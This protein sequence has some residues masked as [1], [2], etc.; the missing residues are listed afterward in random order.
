MPRKSQNGQ[1]DGALFFHAVYDVV[2]AIPS[3]KAMTYAGVARRAGS[4][5]AFRAVGNAMH[6]NRSWPAVPCHR[7]IPSSGM[8]G[9][10]SGKGGPAEKKKLLI[11]EGIRFSGDRIDPKQILR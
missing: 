4:A 10:W 9:G 11:A 8:L 3:G 7:V 1:A 5:G 6:Q 2:R